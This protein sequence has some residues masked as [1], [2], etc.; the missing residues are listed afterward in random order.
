MTSSASC[1]Q[2]W[3]LKFWGAA[4]SGAL[5]L[6]GRMPSDKGVR[7]ALGFLLCCR[8]LVLSRWF[9]YPRSSKAIKSLWAFA[10]QPF[11]ICL[12]PGKVEISTFAFF[13]ETGKNEL[14]K[15]YRAWRSIL[16]FCRLQKHKITLHLCGHGL[17]LANLPLFLGKSAS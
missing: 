13:R 6:R 2:R 1:S 11:C 14:I 8:P 7:T 17:F 16:L 12:S 4:A 15:G 3:L 5:S 10:L 9:I